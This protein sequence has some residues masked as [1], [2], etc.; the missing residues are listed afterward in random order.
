MSKDIPGNAMMS[1]MAYQ[2]EM[3]RLGQHL[4]RFEGMVEQLFEED[5]E[6]QGMSIRV[7]QE[8]GQDYLVTVRAFEEGKKVVAFNSGATFAEVLRGTLARLQNR[9]LRWKADSYAGK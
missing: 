7:P 8:E 4:V 9:S 5:I 2:K 6:I 3:V 1:Q